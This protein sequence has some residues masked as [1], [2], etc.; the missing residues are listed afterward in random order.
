MTILW[1]HWLVFGLVLVAAEMAAPGGF[2]IIF[3]GVSALLIGVLARLGVAEPLWAQLILFSVLSVAS[4]LLFRGR[5]MALL[6]RDG[7]AA[8]DALVGQSCRAI[9]EL[10][11]HGSGRV[12]LRGAAW[13]AHNGTEVVIGCDAVCRVVRVDGLT[14]HVEPEG[15][16]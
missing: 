13:E 10:A 5:L 15:G 1:W 4:L 2:Y 7:S 14:L 6:P 9:N 3:F 16:R 12:E 11:P 8:V